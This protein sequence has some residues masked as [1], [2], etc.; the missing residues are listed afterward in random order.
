MSLQNASPIMCEWK[1][2]AG[3]RWGSAPWTN[4][5]FPQNVL[6]E[7]KGILLIPNL[8]NFLLLLWLISYT[9]AISFRSLY[10]ILAF[11]QHK[12]RYHKINL[13]VKSGHFSVLKANVFTSWQLKKE[14]KKKKRWAQQIGGA[15]WS[16]YGPLNAIMRSEICLFLF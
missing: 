11:T 7:V 5:F 14:K 3:R 4:G 1:M 15:R 9:T 13:P 6:K 16:F 2:S 8:G 10:A 12:L